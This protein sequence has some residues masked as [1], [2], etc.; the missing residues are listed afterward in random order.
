MRTSHPFL[1]YDEI[2]FDQNADE[3]AMNVLLNTQDMIQATQSNNSCKT[4]KHGRHHP[5]N[6]RKR[7]IVQT[8]GIVA[9]T[10][11][12]ATV[13]P[14]AAHAAYP[15]KTVRILVGFPTGTAPDIIARLIAE[16]LRAQWGKSVIVE[17]KPGA[18][19]SIAAS[20]I[21]KSNPD[22]YSLLMAGNASLTVIR[23]LRKN[24]PYHPEKDL[25]PVTIAAMTPN[26]LVVRKDLPVR[27]VQDLVALAREKPNTLT[28]GYSGIGTSQ[29]LAAE[30]FKKMANVSIRPVTYNGGA[31]I[32]LDM[33]AGRVD[34]CF[35]NVAA[36]LPPGRKGSVRMLAVTSLQS[37]PQAPELPMIQET[38]FPGFE[39]TAWFALM[40]PNRT[41]TP[42]I[43]KLYADAVKALS[44]KTLR[45]KFDKMGFIPVGNTPS[46]VAAI[47]RNK[48]KHWAKLIQSI[49]LKRQ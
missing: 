18:G 17:N 28:Y 23:H 29:H 43:N 49:D 30:M 24:F 32:I 13:A 21:A 16:R 19:G 39:A 34:L 48:S 15:E 25:A 11:L 37:M 41:P 26:I 20:L 9:M 4:R 35:C 27:S 31:R 36:T 22:G 40:A 14:P 33:M 45:K 12:I 3:D 1:N 6:W 8:A 5:I 10:A 7:P 42:I 47:V 2:Q 46:E 44:D 38:G